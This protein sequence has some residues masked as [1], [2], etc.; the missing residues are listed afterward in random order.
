ML[1][2][3]KKLKEEQHQASSPLQVFTRRIL[4][5]ALYAIFPLTIFRMY[6]YHIPEP[7][8]PN[9]IKTSSSIQM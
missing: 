1:F 3:L 5:L 2:S 4:P 9:S 8:S 6:F 7:Q